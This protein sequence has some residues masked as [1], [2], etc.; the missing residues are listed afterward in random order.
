VNALYD[1]PPE[2]S[3]QVIDAETYR[4]DAPTNVTLAD[5]QSDGWERVRL[6]HRDRPDHAVLGQ[7]A[8]SAMFAYTILD[9]QN[10]SAVVDRTDFVNVEPDGRVNRSDPFDYGL[11]ETDGWDGDRLH[12][13]EKDGETAYVWKLVWDSPAEATA[14]ADGYRRL[15]SHWGGER[16]RDGVWRVEEGPFADAYRIRVDGDT[17]V[18]TNAP[19]V[20]E[21]SDVRGSR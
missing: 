21:L 10:R 5:R 12:V 20:A 1:A 9:Q 6:D 7:S 2:S 17:V 13:Y 11:A 14:F 15:L 4:E 16:V 8:L 19:T 18:I 3:E